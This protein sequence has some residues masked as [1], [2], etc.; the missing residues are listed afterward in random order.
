MAESEDA[1]HS[2]SVPGAESQPGQISGST[3]EAPSPG[4][5]EG[6][7]AGGSSDEL[8]ADRGNPSPS[9]AP[10]PL[11]IQGVV[12]AG[13]CGPDDELDG[14]PVIR[15]DDEEEEDDD[16]WDMETTQSTQ[17]AME[18]DSRAEPDRRADE[19]SDLQSEGSQTEADRTSPS[20]AVSSGDAQRPPVAD[21]EMQTVADSGGERRRH[22]SPPPAG[23]EPSL[24]G[25]I[26]QPNEP[27]GARRPGD[28]PPEA[29][30]R[31][32]ELEMGNAV[33][34]CVFP[35]VDIKEEPIDE[36]YD[37][38]L[39][40]P[41]PQRSIKLEPDTSELRISSVFSVG[42]NSTSPTAPAG[43]PPPPVSAGARAPALPPRAPQ[44][45][46]SPAQTPPP[47]GATPPSAVRVSCSGCTKVLQKGQTA[48]QRK[49]SSQLFCSTVCLTGYALPPAP[50]AGQRKTCHYCLK[51]IG[52]PK[53]VIIAPV[54]MSGTVKDFCSQVCLSSFDFK[55]NS[56]GVTKCSM[57]K[58]TAVI[59]H[60]VNYQGAVHKLCSDTCFSLFR[61]SNNLT[62]NCC[63]TCGNYCP[64]AT[65]TCHL[66]QVEAAT[67]KFCCQGCLTA[68]KV[69]PCV[70]CRALRSM[71]EMA[72][73]NKSHPQGQVNGNSAPP[74]VLTAPP[75]GLPMP[76]Q[77][78]GTLP[79]HSAPRHG[80]APPHGPGPV[81]A[82]P[83]P[84]ARGHG[85]ALPSILPR[86]PAPAQAPPAL[87]AGSAPAARAVTRGLAKLTCRQCPRVFTHKPELIQIKS[88][89]ALF[90]G[91]TCAEEHKKL[92]FVLARCEYCKLDKPV[93]DVS[94]FNH[95]ERPFC[96]EGCKLLFKHDLSK[97]SGAPCRACAYCTNMAQK[98]IQNHFGGKLEEFCR[99]ECMSLYTVLFYQMAK[100]DW[101]QHQGKLG[102]S[103]K[104]L[105]EMK[106][107]CDLP[108]LLQFSSQN[109]AYDQQQAQPH[110]ALEQPH[111]QPHG[112][113][114]A[115]EHPH[116]HP[117]HGGYEQP[118]AQ[119]GQHAYDPHPSSGGGTLPQQI[120]TGVAP[121]CM[122]PLPHPAGPHPAAPPFP[123]YASKE[124]TPVIANVVS[125]ASA[126]TGQPYITAN[127]AL[128]GAVPTA[129]IQPKI[130]GDASTQTDAMKPPAPPRRVLKNKALLCKPISQNKGTLCKPHSRDSESQTDE[131]MGQKILVL[132]V[133][134]PVFIPVPMHLY[135]QY[136]PL[137]LGLPVPLPVPL[138]VPT[139]PSCPE[140]L[141][142]ASQ[143]PAHTQAPAME[144]EE[145]ERDKPV[146]Y[147]EGV[148]TP[149]SW[150]EEPV[151]SGPRLGASDHEA[152]STS[153]LA[154]P[155][156]LDLEADFP[157]DS[158]PFAK[159]QNVISRNRGRRRP[160][161]GFPPRKRVRPASPEP[162][163]LPYPSKVPHPDPHE[164]PKILP[165][166]DPHEPPKILPYPDPHE[167]P[168]I[169]PNPDPH[170]HPKIL[171][172]PDPH[173]PPKIL[174]N[175]DPHEPP[176]ILPN[177]DPHEHPK[178]LPKPDPHESPKIL[179]NPEPAEHPENIPNPPKLPHPKS[180]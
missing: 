116:A 39:V 158:E 22:P 103:L 124:A 18:T 75:S 68:T 128:Q 130:N 177:P 140:R 147:G 57:C 151:P 5:A 113:Q 150:E 165:N 23:A 10:S 46:T 82:P 152:D 70:S 43:P 122:A 144:E 76:P 176:K 63:E 24:G 30:C 94:K 97:R 170:E 100:C 9:P 25:A 88:Q 146:S 173:E 55:R 148:S 7:P 91:K 131:V 2:E 1:K 89:M 71:P 125:L 127:T 136:T 45:S 79:P 21:V 167:P 104:W 117:P 112:Q 166:P 114:G 29:L 26:L 20:T 61:A 145:E 110:A 58:M 48:F 129:F 168:K 15:A 86:G 139:S 99:E 101:C 87:G 31:S 163:N 96:S 37:R 77:A 51:E 153:T 44:T 162:Q 138:V 142:C 171:L 47:R 66:L 179:P 133:P 56:S 78:S 19:S 36:E 155:T 164:P 64:S 17:D 12:G 126:P 120:P 92:N 159:D 81:Q 135:S 65:S 98:M 156:Q 74:E 53:D 111:H 132:P 109:C 180:L 54:D 52:N 172:N 73:L 69:T 175:P 174:P 8:R 134:V 119:H 84:S 16:D 149:H 157:L 83:S 6:R 107:F 102:E 80:L 141:P 33:G 40:P 93:R 62:M 90:C 60:E 115:F 28:E 27:R 11:Q 137:P 169:L 41:P 121:A 38:A 35:P 34:P 14:A 67:K 143:E 178:I 106:H 108:C 13:L 49:G 72:N 95:A 105:G 50:K 32:Q 4:T 123:T 42:E 160:R 118:S 161:E 3:V 85:P 59:N 154:T